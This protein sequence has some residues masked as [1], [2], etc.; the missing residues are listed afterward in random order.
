MGIIFN[1]LKKKNRVKLYNQQLEDLVQSDYDKMYRI[2]FSYTHDHQQALDVIQ[3][4][5]QKALVSFQKIEKIDNFQAWFFKIL[6]RTAIDDWRKHKRQPA[7]VEMNDWQGFE[8]LDKNEK[9]S[10]LE[11]QSIL[12]QTPSPDREIIVLKFFEGFTL[13]EI[14][15]ILD[16]SE[17]TVKTKMYRSLNTLRHILE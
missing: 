4:S 14:A 9:I 17:S 3:D 16:M 2:A 5:F 11:L 10:H 7:T 1:Q 13:Y 8:Y 6:V 12:E 15:Q